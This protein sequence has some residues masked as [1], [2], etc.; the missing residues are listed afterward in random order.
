MVSELDENSSIEF[1]EF[2]QLVKGGKKTA[3]TMKKHMNE[4]EVK[5][6]DI[7]FDFFKKLTNNKL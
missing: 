6:S 4:D 2:L 5:D 7:I 1:D 3:T